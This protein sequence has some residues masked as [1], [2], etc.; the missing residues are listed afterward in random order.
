[1]I[2]HP[3]M[4]DKEQVYYILQFYFLLGIGIRWIY[5]SFYVY[6]HAK[7]ATQ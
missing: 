7:W 6:F 3:H 4:I 5:G 1:M 2:H